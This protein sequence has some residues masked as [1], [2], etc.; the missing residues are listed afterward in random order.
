MSS[1]VE[2]VKLR[3]KEMREHK[4]LNQKLS[5]LEHAIWEAWGEKCEVLEF[6]T[7]SNSGLGGVVLYYYVRKNEYIVHDFYTESCS[8]QNGDYCSDLPTA[9]MIF[10]KRARLK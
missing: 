7:T 1:T 5:L 8:L 6:K 2:I 3:I 4:S 9:Q 10:D